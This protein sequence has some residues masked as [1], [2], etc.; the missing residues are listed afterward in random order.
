MPEAP[1]RIEIEIVGTTDVHGHI[2][3]HTYFKGEQEEDLGLAKIA[4]LLKRKRAAN[5]HVVYVDSGDL[6]QGSPLADWFRRHGGGLEA[7]DPMIAT[8]NLMGCAA[9]GVGNHDF[10]YGLEVLYKARADA[11]FPFLAANVYRAGTDE[12]QFDPYVI[13]DV[14]GVRV[15]VIGAAP[16]G[17]A[18]WDRAF[19]SGRLEIRDIVAAFRKYVP[20]VREK[21]A[22]IVVGVPHTG[23]GGDGEYGP[24][25]AGYSAATGLP[26]ENVGLVLAREIPGLDALFLGHTHQ[27]VAMIENGVALVQA[28][29]G[30]KRLA[31]VRFVLE[32]RSGRWAIVEK[33]PE[34]LSTQGIPADPDVLALTQDAHRGTLEYVNAPVATTSARWWTD[35]ARLEDTAL[36]DLIAEVQRA[37]TG[38]QLSAVAAFTTEVELQPGPISIAQIAAIYPVENT[39]IAVEITGQQLRAFLEHSARY[40]AP[41]SPGA[42]AINRDIKGYNFDMVTGVDYDID[43]T[44]PVGSRITRLEY[45]GRPVKDEDTF[46]MALNGYRQGGGGGYDMVR[47]APVVYSR[48]E[49]VRE[50]LIEYLREKKTIEPEEY[51]ERNWQIVPEGVI[52][53]ETMC[54]TAVDSPAQRPDTGGMAGMIRTAETP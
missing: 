54:Y 40:F 16:P 13:L 52:D 6:L 51:F 39:L 20:E 28:E 14:G 25:Y 36:M 22:D 33:T 43:V 26:R 47:G 17:I 44:R 34:T 29:M 11:R 8:L 10:N 12:L 24:T 3:P 19:V 30:A 45:Q 50:L 5:P 49:N 38:A 37:R 21:G 18:I 2:R 15:G 35:C 42:P 23:L 53:R 27:D 46:T 32:E 41:Y 7:V 1:K 9:W 4:T 31:C 48:E